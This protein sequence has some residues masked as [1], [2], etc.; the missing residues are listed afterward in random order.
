MSHPVVPG[1][2]ILEGTPRALDWLT[3]G[4]DDG[5]ARWKPAPERW[6]VIE[7]VAHLAEIEA[8]GF[9]GR[10]EAM[11]AEESPRL[12]GIDPMQLAREGHYLERDLAATL[13]AF[14]D[15]RAL[16][17]EFLRGLAPADL[18]RPG[19]HGDLGP[20]TLSHLLHEWPLHDLG[21][22]RQIAELVRARRFHP[23]IGPWQPQ[24]PIRP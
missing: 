21:H 17:L 18:S 2:E 13:A 16:S 7:V 6:C 5:D 4:L 22:V 15:E 23:H 10:A 8:R 24:H 3:A 19:I 11:M 14:R 9:R 1:F 12:P 20:I